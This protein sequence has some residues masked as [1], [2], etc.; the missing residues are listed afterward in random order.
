M[1]LAVGIGNLLRYPS[2]VYKNY[3][4][5]WFIPY[6]MA[7]IFVGIP[8]LLLEI[9]LGQAYRGGAVVAFN[10]VSHRLRGLGL[11]VVFVGYIVT[12]YYVVIL[13]WAMAFF[14]HSFTSPLP[15]AGGRREIESFFFD[16]VVRNKV[17]ETGDGIS[18]DHLGIV[19]ETIGWTLLLW[20]LVYLCI[21]KGVG[22]TGRIVYVSMLFPLAML[23]VITIRGVTLENA[24]RGIKLYIATWDGSKLGNGQ[25]W[26]DAVGQIFF[27]IG[28]GFGSF[29]AYASYNKKYANAVQDSLIIALSNSFYE[30]VAGFAAFGVIGFLNIPRDQNLTTF[31]IAFIT[32]PQALAELPGSNVWSVLFFV[33]V[34]LLGI[35]SAFGLL[36]GAVTVI[37]DTDWGNR[38]AR[39][40][41]V[42]VTTASAAVLSIMYTTEFGYYLL[43]AVDTWFNTVALILSM[44]VQCAGVTSL[45]RYKDVVSQTGWLAFAVAN[46]SYVVSMILLVV[47]GHTVCSWVGVIVFIA[48]LSVGTLLSALVAQQP[49]IR[50]PFARF[51]FVDKLWWLSCYSVR[52]KDVFHGG[53]IGQREMVLTT[54]C[55]VKLLCAQSEQLRQDLNEIVAKG[56]NWNIP[57]LWAPMLRWLTAPVLIVILSFSYEAFDGSMRSNALHVFGFVFAHVVAA[58]L[59]GGLVVPRLFDVFVSESKKGEHKLQYAVEPREVLVDGDDEGDKMGVGD[60][61]DGR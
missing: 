27:S 21:F 8:L 61:E 3:G 59:V 18:Y 10:R 9:S 35:D 52:S 28:T 14:R 48:V 13:A 54:R 42:G 30:I 58:L 32:Y 44:W 20:V 49:T 31:T 11:S 60:E 34:I 2:I 4:V 29:I 19:G 7:L 50:G 23:L 33:T 36:E 15:W 41:S 17:T 38:P 43:D 25:I 55:D 39:W 53:R 22:L 24:W 16:T 51:G 46:G 37:V 47:V 56:K 45:Y 5:Q 1:G 6:F 12:T 26:K 40:I 57:V